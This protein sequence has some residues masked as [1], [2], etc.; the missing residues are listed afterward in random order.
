MRVTIDYTDGTPAYLSFEFTEYQDTLL[1][2]KI[3]DKVMN[4]DRTDTTYR[5]TTNCQ[6]RVDYKDAVIRELTFEG[7]SNFIK[8]LLHITVANHWYMLKQE[9]LHD[10]EKEQ[11]STANADKKPN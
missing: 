1:F 5:I 4:N 8:R 11:E 7:D 9:C 2:R 3:I 10:I 6:M